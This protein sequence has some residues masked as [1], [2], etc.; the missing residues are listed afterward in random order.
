MKRLLPA[1]LLALLALAGP[2]LAPHPMDQPITIPYGP[3]GADGALLGGDQLGR[4]VLS[5]LLHGGRELVLASLVVAVLVTAIA[6]VLGVAG[7]L[8]PALGRVVERAADVF[9]L[10][11]AV[12]GILLVTQSWPGGGRIALVAA[13]VALGTPYAMRF[14]A[15][16]AAP[17]V[18]AGYVEAA[19]AG[20]ERT[21][22]LVV[23][24]VLP[25][26]RSTVLALFGLR[27]VAAVY[28][29][30]TAAFLQVGPQPPAADWA[31]MI[32]ENSAGIVLNPW[33]VLAPGVAIALLAMSVN[34]AAGALT[35]ED[36]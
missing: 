23:R 17:V 29:V 26:L 8:R 31:L 11:P 14:M 13:A 21:W 24:E 15:A 12:L 22:H 28:V 1:L 7:A 30:S 34:L 16:A 36:S 33:A 9:M 2:L 10:L 19:V 25:N 27:F 4:D 3:A 32:R 18:A 20:G 6:A 35:R 5:R